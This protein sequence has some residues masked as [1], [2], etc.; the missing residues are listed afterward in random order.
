[1]LGRYIAFKNKQL[2]KVYIL[3]EAVFEFNYLFIIPDM[4]ILIFIFFVFFFD[5]A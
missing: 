4:V 5:I 3:S 2:L 1:M